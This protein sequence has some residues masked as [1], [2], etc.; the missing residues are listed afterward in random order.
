MIFRVTS[1]ISYSMILEAKHS[2]SKFVI[3]VQLSVS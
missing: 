2:I 3:Y 1:S